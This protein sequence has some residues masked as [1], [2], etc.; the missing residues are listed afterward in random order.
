MTHLIPRLLSLCA[1]SICIATAAIAED[2]TPA[3]TPAPAEYSNAVHVTTLLRTT[4]TATGQPIE[5]VKTDKPLVTTVLVEI[6]PGKET[7]WHIHKMPCYA[8]VLSGK[9]DVEIAGGKTLTYEAG[10][11]IAETVNTPHNG[12][13]NGTEPVKIV[14]TVIGE[15]GVPIAEKL[16]KPPTGAQ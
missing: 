13:N 1:L 7:G 8:Y 15:R 2:P 10:Q 4:V 5:Y 14:M 16:A 3:P 11:A 9:L 12:K 6:P